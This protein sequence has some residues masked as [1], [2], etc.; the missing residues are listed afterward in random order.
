MDFEL[1]LSN[2]RTV[3]GLH[4]SGLDVMALIDFVDFI[5]EGRRSLPM[6]SFM[7]NVLQLCRTSAATVRDVVE[8]RKMVLQ[9]IA[10]VKGDRMR[11]QRAMSAVE[12][13]H[14]SSDVRMR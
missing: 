1:M 4:A 2:A 13:E 8:T 6:G 3:Q 7:N 9:N 5:F 10:A 11:Q 12:E 14:A